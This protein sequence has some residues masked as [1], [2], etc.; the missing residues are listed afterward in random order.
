MLLRGAYGAAASGAHATSR[1][2]YGAI[3]I[4]I[5]SILLAIFDARGHRFRRLGQLVW[6]RK[7]NHGVASEDGNESV[8]G[9]DCIA[10]RDRWGGI[11]RGLRLDR[12][13]VSLFR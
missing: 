1:A 13:L 10:A 5:L 9:D 7:I 4:A 8:W 11:A 2:G 6:S 3:F 12:L